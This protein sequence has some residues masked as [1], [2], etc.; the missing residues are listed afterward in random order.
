MAE[1]RLNKIVN[2]QPNYQI[3]PGNKYRNKKINRSSHAEMNV[4]DYNFENKIYYIISLRI[5]KRGEII[6]GGE[7]CHRCHSRLEK[8]MNIKNIECCFFLH[9]KFYLISN[10]IMKY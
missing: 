10:K 3:I 8:I 9:I 6:K 4:L 2:I 1:K 7:P 5:N